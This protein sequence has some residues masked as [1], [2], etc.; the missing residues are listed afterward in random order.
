[1]KFREAALAGVFV[2]LP[3]RSEDE[4]GYFARTWCRREFEAHGLSPALV[5]CGTSFN[6]H[7]GTLR[8]MHY[9]AEPHQ[10]V[11]LIRC[12]RGAI[13]DVVIDLRPDSPTHRHHVAVR[14]S[15]QDG[16]LLYVPEGFAHGFQTLEDDSEV[17]YQ[18]S[19][20]YHPA[21]AR[22]V[23]WDDPAFGIT[24]PPVGQRI[25]SER[26]RSWP[27]YRD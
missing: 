22:G 13:H 26:D 9:Q 20:F 6:R 2:I 16:N 12:T 5:Q 10:E 18:M 8:G 4:R 17:F 7:R 15:A 27:D 21:A 24:W 3:E 1:M 19:E 23:R 14:L 25:L 11:K